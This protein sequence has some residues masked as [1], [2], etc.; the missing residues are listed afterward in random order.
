MLRRQITRIRDT[1]YPGRLLIG[2]GKFIAARKSFGGSFHESRVANYSNKHGSTAR[3]NL[4]TDNLCTVYPIMRAVAF[5]PSGL[6]G[7]LF[8]M[9][10]ID[11]LVPRKI[12]PFDSAR[13]VEGPF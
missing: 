4:T 11:T 13:C 8:D 6:Q 7:L 10:L 5:D 3:R 12:K 2:G 1:S 9:T